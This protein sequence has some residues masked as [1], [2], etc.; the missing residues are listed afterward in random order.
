MDSA[1]GPGTWPVS[2]S[3][4]AELTRCP[5]TK[6]RRPTAQATDGQS[7]KT[8]Q[9]EATGRETRHRLTGWMAG[10]FSEDIK[11]KYMR[12]L[13]VMQANLQ[14]SEQEQIHKT[15]VFPSLFKVIQH[16]KDEE[17]TR[18]KPT[19]VRQ[20]PGATWWSTSTGATDTRAYAWPIVRHPPRGLFDWS[21]SKT[22]GR[23]SVWSGTAIRIGKERQ[24]GA[25]SATDGSYLQ[26]LTRYCRSLFSDITQHCAGKKRVAFS[27]LLYS[28]SFKRTR[29][30][31]GGKWEPR[32]RRKDGQRE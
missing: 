16:S 8:H 23:S 6:P 25:L 26:S 29:Q 12:E 3:C 27:D 13:P 1:F 20:A 17:D 28:C 18:S 2:G 24:R 14:P 31:A 30:A 5:T 11:K 22:S 4:R 32:L 21:T 15:S 19:A 10:L 7:V 9:R